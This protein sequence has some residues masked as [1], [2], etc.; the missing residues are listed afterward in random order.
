MP[1]SQCGT[2]C[3]PSGSSLGRAQRRWDFAEAPRTQDDRHDVGSPTPDRPHSG[4]LGELADL[5]GQV[6]RDFTLASRSAAGARTSTGRADRNRS[7]GP[8]STGVWLGSV[9]DSGAPGRGRRRRH[10]VLGAGSAC[11]A[12]GSRSTSRRAPGH[13][14]RFGV[15]D[16]VATWAN[17]AF[18]SPEE[19]KRPAG[20]DLPRLFAHVASLLPGA[21]VT[22]RRCAGATYRSTGRTQA[23]RTH[24]GPWRDG[25]PVPRPMTPR[26]EQIV[27][28][29]SPHLSWCR[30]SAVGWTTSRRSTNGDG[31]AAPS[32]RKTLLSCGCYRVE[33]SEDFRLA[34]TSGV[35]ANRSAPSGA[36][37]PKRLVFE[38]QPVTPGPEE[39]RVRSA[40]S[41]GGVARPGWAGV[42]QSC[43]R[44]QHLPAAPELAL[45]VAD[46]PDC[47]GVR[48]LELAH[49][50]GGLERVVAGH[51]LGTAHV[52]QLVDPHP[53]VAVGALVGL[54]LGALHLRY[55][56]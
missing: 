35:S 38:R 43:R 49:D 28:A 8:C 19:T 15:F 4:Q 45:V 12:M 52:A 17:S 25:A 54:A 1:R 14:R 33:T 39:V 2:A 23:P 22:S 24:E 18:C 47:R 48:C 21:G 5:S 46:R 9:L 30:A 13:P 6:R 32:V 37:R 53:A 50:L 27:R 34:F 41:S 51:R 40:F 56:T 42:G 29:A 16:A 10:P 44:A 3:A 31:F 20:R 11:G 26:E 55:L 7:R 36:D